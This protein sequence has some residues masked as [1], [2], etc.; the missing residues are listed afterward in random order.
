MKILLAEDD[1]DMGMAVKALLTRNQYS[2][3]LVDNG[4]DALDFLLAGGYDAAI[5]DIMMPRMDG[6]TV[7]EKARKQGIGIPV[8]M[9]TAMG[10]TED[11][12]SGFDAGADDYLPKPFEGAE[13]LARLRA[14]LRRRADY[15]PDLSVYE[16]LTLDKTSCL[17]TCGSRS[18]TISG[19]AYQML[20]MLMSTP[21]R[22]ISADQFMEHIWGWDSDAEINVVWVN[23][24][25]LRKLLVRIGSRVTIKVIRGQGYTLKADSI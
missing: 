14:I 3:D 6:L 5:L 10:E 25:Y 21:G 20:D 23:I 13:L 24:S 9:L 1:K 18:E 7:L 16:D 2:V 11:R 22:V 17:L 8:M 19:K 4:E 15:H 12:I